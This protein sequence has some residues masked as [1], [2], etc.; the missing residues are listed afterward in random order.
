MDD[1]DIAALRT[2]SAMLIFAAMVG[3]P[4]YGT[5]PDASKACDLAEKIAAEIDKRGWKVFD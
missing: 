4:S 2:F 5:T 1:N 3:S